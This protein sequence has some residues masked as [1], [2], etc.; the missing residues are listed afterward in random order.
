MKT[1]VTSLL[2]FFVCSLCAQNKMLNKKLDAY[3]NTAVVN[4][5]TISDERKAEL[6]KISVWMAERIASGKNIDITVI[7]THNSRRS[8]FGQAWLQ[9]A[10]HYYGV[11]KVSTFSGGTEATAFN[12]RALDALKRAGMRAEV[13]GGEGKNLKYNLTYAKSKSAMLMYSKKYNDV[14]NPQKDFAA[15]MVCSQAD[16]ACPIVPGADVRFSIPFEDPKVA[17]NT[18]LEKSKYDERCLQI[19]TEMF[20]IVSKAKEISSK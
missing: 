5:K 14:Q 9:A 12:K 10:S 1:L 20:Y 15:I 6:E 13:I 17:D 11:S 4:F 3:V 16:E 2:V 18:P 19:A 7:C 8:H